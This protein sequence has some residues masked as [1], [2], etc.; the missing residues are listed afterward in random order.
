MTRHGP[1]KPVQLDDVSKAII[2]QLQSDGRR[3]YAEIGKAVG[4]QRGRRAPAG[5]E[6]HRLRRHAGRRRHRP[7]AARLL[8]PGDDRHPG[9]RRHH[10]WSPRRSARS[11]PSTTSCSPPAASTSS[12][13]S[14]ARTTTTSS[15]CSTSSIRAHRRRAVHRDLRL[16]QT[17]Q[18]V[19][20]LGNTITI[21]TMEQRHTDR[22]RPRR[23]RR[24][25]AAEGQGPPLDALRPP[26]GA[27]GARRA[28][29]RQGRGPPHL[30]LAGQE[31]H[32]RPLR[33]LRRQRRPR[34]QAPRRG[35]RASRRRSSP[36]SRSGRT[37]IPPRSSSPTGSPTT[38]PAT[39]TASS[40]PPA[41]ARPSR[42]RSSSP[43]TTGS[44]RAGPTKHKVI[45]RAIAYHGTP[46]GRPRDHRHPGDE[47][48]VRAGHPRRLP[49]AEHQLL[50][51]RRD[52]LRTAPSRGVRP[53]GG[54]PHRGDDPV[55]GPRDGRGGLPRAGAELG[56]MLPAAP[57]LLPAGARDL[58]PVRRAARLATRS[59]APSAASATCSR[60]T[61]TATCPT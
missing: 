31:V 39:S 27:G 57:R 23:R 41:A 46:A 3:S 11:R 51:R 52:G 34:A 37:R 2:E 12:P 17:A 35:R 54:E 4:P 32:R 15:T 40:S 58:R 43:S 61:P 22:R 33:P 7:D 1:R 16:S 9:H 44:C 38:R 5:A 55:R 42:P 29:H 49:G 59:S 26:V 10:A 45:S 28:H 14:S 36:S 60:A 53:V 8:P 20:Q 13:R 18:A 48:D 25:P 47:G 24:R 19:L 50:P 56:R 21:T 6:A 30:G